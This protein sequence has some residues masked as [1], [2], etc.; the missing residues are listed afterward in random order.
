M[1]TEIKYKILE[2]KFGDK[3]FKI[4]EDL[5]D[6]GWYLY[7]YDQK[8]K[9]IADHLQNDLETVINFAFEE[10]KVPMT[11][12]VDS[13]DISFVQEETNK[14]LA[15]RVLSHFDSKKLIDWAIMLMGKGFDSESLIILAGLNS[16][17]TEE[18]E[19]YFWQTIDELGLD[20]NRT[21]FE[22]IENYAIYVAESVVNKKIAPKDGLTIMQD[23]VRSTDYSKRYVQFYEIDEDLDYLKYDNHTIFNSGLT[24]KNADKYITREFE[25]FLETEKYKIDDKTRE[26]AYCKS[27]DKIEKPKLK[28]IRNWF[29]KVKYQTWVCGLCESKSILHFSS[30][31]GKEII[32]KRKTQPNN[33]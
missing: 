28:N 18:R 4:E 31:K 30:Q 23:I 6:V 26:L 9:C 2:C 32:L 14:I 20:I 29:G 27:C 25:L 15:Q 24:L 13:K 1:G 16:D 19:Q 8:G 17:T 12:W 21:D 7:V 22:L 33:V 3:R 11:N 10:Y 5:P